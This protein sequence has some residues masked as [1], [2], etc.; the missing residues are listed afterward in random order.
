MLFSNTPNTHYPKKRH[1]LHCTIGLVLA[2]AGLGASAQAPA[3]PASYP[4]SY[5]KL[6]EGAQKEGRLLIYAATDVKAA[7]PVLKDF[8]T[9]Y[10]FIKVEYNDMNTTELY[11]RYI[12]EQASGG[13]SGDV[14]WTSAMDSAMKLAQQYAAEYATP[15]SSNLPPWA[16]WKNKA[17]GTTF[18]PAV[19]I[20]NKRLVP[21]SDVPTTHAAFAKLAQSP[22]YK[23]KITSYDIEKSAL[24]YLLAVQDSK[25][26]P[27]NLDFLRAVG[28]AGLMVQSSTGTMMERISS[29]ENLLGYNIL[30]SYAETRAKT[31]S[32]IGVAYPTDHTLIVSRV[33]FISKKAKNPNA[34]RLWLDYLLSARGQDVLANQ[35]ELF[36]IRRDIPGDADVAGLT[37]KLGDALKPIPVDESLLD[38]LE[39]KNR[40]AFIQEWRKAAGK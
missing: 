9:L 6:I 37:Q 8:Q 40:L 29:G 14:V 38:F 4:S 26:N 24:G 17:Y 20:Y 30:G 21:A 33:A 23:N 2:C 10:P 31:D 19:F 35:S 36:S 1:T 27:Q 5:P 7:A 34:A 12:S 16:N 25:H 3:Y 11:N 22:A 39:Q 28:S 18:E 13:A 15:E 32:S